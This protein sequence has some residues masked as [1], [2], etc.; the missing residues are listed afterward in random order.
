MHFVT[1][2]PLD[3]AA[4]IRLHQAGVWRY[5]RMLG[6]DAAT[7]DDLTQETFLAVLRQPFEDRGTGPAAAYLRTVARN[8]LRKDRR[9]RAMASLDDPAAAN[10]LDDHF[11]ARCADGGDRYV[12]ALRECLS[13]LDGRARRALDL[14]VTDGAGREA[15]GAAL[16]IGA[17]GVKSLL[18]RTRD[19]LRD[20]VERRL[21]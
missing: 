14:Q 1:S 20:C 3:T 13:G 7:A 4:L 9:R 11:A 6:C 15:I 12:D 21:R 10:A 8:L 2:Q 18:R 17:D 19:A 16:G 5:L